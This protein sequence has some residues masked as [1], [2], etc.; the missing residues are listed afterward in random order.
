MRDL[1]LALLLVSGAGIYGSVN[2]GGPADGGTT[3]VST[4]A[5]TT[6]E[7]PDPPALDEEL[8]AQYVHSFVNAERH[9]HGESNLSADPELAEIADG[10]S[11]DMA[12]RDYFGHKAPNGSNFQDRYARA[13]Y[14]CQV[15]VGNDIYASG[16]ENIGGAW[17][18]TQVRE[19]DGIVSYETPRE[20][21]KAI[22]QKWM[23]SPPHRENL[24]RSEWRR[25]GIGIATTV[26]DGRL[27]VIATQ[28]FC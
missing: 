24:L 3:P 9:A 26:E 18:Q 22:V 28:N 5:E 12:K 15:P 20:L 13:G 4:P 21:S 23:K 2:A 1:L 17:Y 25:E 11:E 16:A 27:K 14:E 10:H 7:T 6:T 8:V 19:S